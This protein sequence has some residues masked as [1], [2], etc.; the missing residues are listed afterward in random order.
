[1]SIMDTL[2]EVNRA[3]IKRG[4]R[5]LTIS[6]PEEEMEEYE[7][8]YKWRKIMAKKCAGGRKKGGKGK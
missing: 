6:Y 3:R 8:K 5:A 7:K 2:Y 1:M 4:K